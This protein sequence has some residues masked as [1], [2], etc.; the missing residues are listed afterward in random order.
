VK[1]DGGN[2]VRAGR[3]AGIAA[4]LSVLLAARG[5]ALDW[6][7]ANRIL[8]GT[9]GEDRGDHFHNGIDIGGGNQAVR[10]VLPG[11]LVF[12]YD[13]GLDYTSLP[14]GVGSY[15][16]LHHGQGLLGVYCHLANGTLGPV[17]TSYAVSDQVGIIGE[18]GDAQGKH[19]HFTLYDRESAS[20][21]NPLSFLPARADRQAPVIRR[22]LLVVGDQ[23]RQLEPR[24]VMKPGRAEV[25]AEIYD[26]REDVSFSWPL[27]PY[28]VSL[29]LDG[30]EVARLAFESIQV[31]EGRSV[32]GAGL[33]TRDQVY[34]ASGLMRLGTIDMHPGESRL[35]VT[36]RDI[37]G[38]E[39]SREIPFTIQE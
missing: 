4:L 31:K 39:T 19:L 23:G 9:F 38:N 5:A 10:P 16:V 37:A 1:R 22:V 13:E 35:K 12:R 24:A 18:S 26:L 6:P 28:S 32:I 2:L 3:R 11:E 34:D 21:I 29:S 17:R 36:A 33:L 27:A 20:A 15:V 30:A 14:R 7:V 25:R 8:T